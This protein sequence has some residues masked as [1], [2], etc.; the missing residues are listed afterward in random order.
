MVGAVSIRANIVPP[1]NTL[2]ISAVSA[3]GTGAKTVQDAIRDAT[4]I[5]KTSKSSSVKGTSVLRT[6]VMGVKNET[7]ALCAG[8]CM[9]QG[10]QKEHEGVEAK[11]VRFAITQ[12]SFTEQ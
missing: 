5:A 6:F 3:H 2:K 9:M 8:S 11:A 10:R 4:N 7:A 12:M 1:A